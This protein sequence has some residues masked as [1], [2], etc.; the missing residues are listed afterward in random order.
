MIVNLMPVGP[1]RLLDVVPFHFRKVLRIW[2]AQRDHGWRQR[3][4][5]EAIDGS[6]GFKSATGE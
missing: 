6:T 3:G 5:V 2:L 1:V 4:E